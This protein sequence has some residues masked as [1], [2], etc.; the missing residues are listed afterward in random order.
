[1][2]SP[3]RRE[4][5]AGQVY[6]EDILPYELS[7]TAYPANKWLSVFQKAQSKRDGDTM[8]ESKI[9]GA[10]RTYI[11]KAED[12]LSEKAKA[13]LGKAYDALKEAAEEF[14]EE[15]MSAFS[16]ALEIEVTPSDDEKEEM[17]EAKKMAEEAKADAEAL[18][19][20][21]KKSIA[22]LDSADPKATAAL[23]L[24]APLVGHK[25]VH[26][27]LAELP[28]SARA[29]IE[30]IKKSADATKAEL[31]ELKKSRAEE[32][33]AARVREMTAK[34]EALPHVP[35]A[36]AEL[37]Q[38]MQVVSEA[39]PSAGDQLGKLLDTVNEVVSKSSIFDA[40]GSPIVPTRNAKS[41][42][43]ELDRLT[44]AMVKKSA[45]DGEPISRAKAMATII[46]T[47]RE[48]AGRVDAEHSARYHGQAR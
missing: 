25:P 16:K 19:E 36:T 34:A 46:E 39:S 2:P 11:A 13:A 48:L 7:P 24:L 10:L 6:L 30:E 27:V 33:K 23:D 26:Q 45:A 21:V 3:D 1:M 41:A 14:T 32:T 40:K 43:A 47:N 31:E 4:D 15:Q 37:A 17:A 9:A 42:Q 44:D 12:G 8:A 20:T 22:H 35:L 38:L 29:Q 5:E 18:R 28:A